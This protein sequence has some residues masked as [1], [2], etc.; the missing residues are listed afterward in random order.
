LGAA[1]ARRAGGLRP[2]SSPLDTPRRTGL[3]EIIEASSLNN[4]LG[5]GEVLAPAT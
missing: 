3:G 1:P 5:S 4:L 2:S